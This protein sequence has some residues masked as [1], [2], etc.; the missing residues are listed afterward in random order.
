[1]LPYFVAGLFSVLP[2][3]LIYRF[4]DGVGLLD[5]S[6]SSFFTEVVLVGP[7]EEFSRFLVF[8]REP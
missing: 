3:L 6:M 1:M 4:V 7:I 2:A 8:S 5:G